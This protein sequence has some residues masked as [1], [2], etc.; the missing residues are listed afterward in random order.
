[1]KIDLALRALILVAGALAAVVLALKGYGAA[2][3]AMAAGGVLGAC[4]TRFTT[5]SE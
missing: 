5:S 4:M 3:P 1:M 2:L